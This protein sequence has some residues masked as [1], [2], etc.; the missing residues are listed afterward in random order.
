MAFERMMS[1]L[2]GVCESDIVPLPPPR[3]AP[4]RELDAGFGSSRSLSHRRI[5]AYVY[6]PLCST[7]EEPEAYAMLV[8]VVRLL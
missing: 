5:P 2:E 3:D 7:S 4:A 1:V 8:V 6:P